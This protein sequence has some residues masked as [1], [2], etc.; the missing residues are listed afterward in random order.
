M[1]SPNPS[2]AR[3]P[4]VE[5]NASTMRKNWLVFSTLMPCCRTASGNRGSASLSLFCTCTCAMS[6]SISAAN[7]MVTVAWP[8]ESAVEA[9]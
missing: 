9:M 3:R 7:V 8:D 5:T 2:L 1:K 4:S 6:G